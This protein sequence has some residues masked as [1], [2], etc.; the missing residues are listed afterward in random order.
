MLHAFFFAHLVKKVDYFRAAL[1]ERW[2][3]NWCAVGVPKLA[4]GSSVRVGVVGRSVLFC[5]ESAIYYLWEQARFCEG[6]F[7]SELSISK[8]FDLKR[9]GSFKFFSNS[10]V[11]TGT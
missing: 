8:K 7:L 4:I 11:E 2:S 6:S 5:R 3:P 10:N 1:L 9:F